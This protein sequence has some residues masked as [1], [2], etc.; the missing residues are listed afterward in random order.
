MDEEEFQR[1]LEK[2][3]KVRPGDWR[4]EKCAPREAKAVVAPAAAAPAP[5]PEPAAEL[6]AREEFRGVPFW[7]ALGQFLGRRL[8][9][10]EAA[11]VVEGLRRDYEAN[12]ARLSL[13]DM[14]E[15]LGRAA[16]S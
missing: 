12:F 6:A 11:A 2:Y 13:D 8:G 5:G 15:M 9:E 7:E 4:G 16:Q 14:E 3:P 1:E 10:G